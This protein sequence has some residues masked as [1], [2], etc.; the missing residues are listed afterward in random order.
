MRSVKLDSISQPFRFLRVARWGRDNE[1]F[2]ST[3]RN[4][5]FIR[6]LLWRLWALKLLELRKRWKISR[7]VAIKKT[8]PDKKNIILKTAHYTAYEKIYLERVLWRHFIVVV[9]NLIVNLKYTNIHN[10]T[11]A[12]HIY[13]LLCDVLVIEIV[14]KNFLQ[15]SLFV[16]IIYGSYWTA[17]NLKLIYYIFHIIYALAVNKTAINSCIVIVCCATVN[18][19]FTVKRKRMNEKNKYYQCDPHGWVI[20]YMS[21]T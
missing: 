5:R 20:S 16:T 4:S 8:R 10:H 9:A 2:S 15:P 3:Q 17:K 19:L 14:L 7:W 6:L 1:I 13:W 21:K 11:I 18:F 12:H